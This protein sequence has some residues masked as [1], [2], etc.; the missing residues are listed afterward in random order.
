[1]D[2]FIQGVRK[3]FPLHPDQ[4]DLM[5][6]NCI[7]HTKNFKKYIAGFPKKA[8][9]QA[10]LRIEFKNTEKMSTFMY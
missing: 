1:M 9:Y 10:V 2:Y 3:Q 6:I 7:F 8:V 4:A 5:L